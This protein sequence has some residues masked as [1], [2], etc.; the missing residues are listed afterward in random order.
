[1]K[2]DGQLDRSRSRA[3][4]PGRSQVRKQPSHGPVVGQHECCELGDPLVPGPVGQ[5]AQQ[6]L[7]DPEPLP[8]LEDGDCDLRPLT[9]FVISHVAGYA[10][11]LA[12]ARIDR[13]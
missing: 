1:V 8:A 5:P 11:A 3:Q 2:V 7:A 4:E 9:T 10:H 12:A 6:R 13:Q